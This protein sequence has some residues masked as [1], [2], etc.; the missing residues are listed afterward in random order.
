[1]IKAW[2][3]WKKG[4]SLPFSTFLKIYIYDRLIIRTVRLFNHIRRK[5]N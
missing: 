2:N 5:F 4:C 3:K 1:M